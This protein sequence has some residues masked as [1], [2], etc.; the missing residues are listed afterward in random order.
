MSGPG[1]GDQ[2]YISSQLNTV[3][4]KAEK[5]AGKLKDGKPYSIENEDGEHTYLSTKGEFVWEKNVIPE[6]VWFNG[7]ADHYLLGDT[8]SELPVVIN[9][10]NGSY[11]DKQSQIIP[12]KVHRG[13]QIYDQQTRMLVQPKL[14][15]SKKGD[16]AL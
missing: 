4:S 13:D 1:A 2:I 12:V 3:L 7:T 10:L 15:G 11:D 8:T 6:Y 16:S 9:P 5:E 14:F